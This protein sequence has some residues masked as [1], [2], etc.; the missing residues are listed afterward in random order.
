MPRILLSFMVSCA[1]VI[2]VRAQAPARAGTGVIA[3]QTID[4]ATGAPV[5]NTLIGLSQRA[6]SGPNTTPTAPNTQLV[7]VMADGQGRFVVRD[8]PK[9]AFLLLATAP[10]Y[11]VSNYGQA[12]ATGPTHTL[13][14]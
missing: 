8:V 2:A 11:I 9:G 10:G 12:R 4:A 7:L 14:V 3:G 1:L 13:D 5:A 6:A